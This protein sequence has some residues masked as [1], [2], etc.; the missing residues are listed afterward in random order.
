M[1]ADEYNEMLTK[2]SEEFK[3]KYHIKKLI[4]EMKSPYYPSANI[5]LY[6]VKEAQVRIE[7]LRE[8][9]YRGLLK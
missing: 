9:Q 6:R 5:P 3:D 7:L 1:R 2:A 8:L 4:E